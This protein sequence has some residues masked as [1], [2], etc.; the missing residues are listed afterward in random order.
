MKRGEDSKVGFAD[1]L[2]ASFLKNVYFQLVLP[3]FYQ[4]NIRPTDIDIIYFCVFESVDFESK[5]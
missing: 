2:S 3:M 5:F 4:C 1:H